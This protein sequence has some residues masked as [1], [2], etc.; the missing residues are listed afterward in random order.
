MSDPCLKFLF[1]KYIHK[2]MGTEVLGSVIYQI[3]L[4]YYKEHL[5]LNIKLFILKFLKV[6]TEIPN[7][8]TDARRRIDVRII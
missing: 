2:H 4:I 8:K 7:F 6:K 1:N 3:M 5:T